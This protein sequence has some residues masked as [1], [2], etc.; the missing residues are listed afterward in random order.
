[1]CYYA[2]YFAQFLAFESFD[3]STWC[4]RGLNAWLSWVL[5]ELNNAS[6]PQC[7]LWKCR[8]F[9][10]FWVT[11]S[12]K[13]R[14]MKTAIFQIG[15]QQNSTS[16][17]SASRSLFHGLVSE[18]DPNTSNTKMKARWILFALWKVS[19][20]RGSGNQQ[21]DP[22]LV[23]IG[24][25][26]SIDTFR[27][28][29]VFSWNSSAFRLMV[30][31]RNFSVEYHFDATTFLQVCRIEIGVVPVA[32]SDCFFERQIEVLLYDGQF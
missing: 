1:M 4:H 17:H 31:C 14:Q 22:V 11:A 19:K 30:R 6:F 10:A 15:D 13:C 16:K 23:W 28:L 26:T 8:N 21:V 18:A 3:S 9:R 12:S 20:Q 25:M 24:W 27:S 5:F 7:H 2:S 29:I 32:R